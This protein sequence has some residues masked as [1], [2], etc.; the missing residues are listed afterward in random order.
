VGCILAAEKI[1]PL[2]LGDVEKI[3]VEVSK[4][5]K[6]QGGTS[7]DV[8]SPDSLETAD[9]SIPYAVA[10][11]LRDGTV[12]LRSYNEAHLSNPEVR[13]FLRTIEV[14]END[15]F[16]RAMDK[17]PVEHR[18][19]VT[20]LTRRGERLVGESGG[21]KGDLAA[22]KTDAEIEDKFRSLTEDYFGAKDTKA[23]LDRLWRLENLGN[24]AEIPRSLILV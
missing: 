10:W 21:D 13:A 20:V 19:R 22:P 2:N 15:E 6:R 11:T 7:E 14:V 23:L 18:V 9:H 4:H 16:T 24:V 17:E 5:A 12:A 3:T 1:A 8:W